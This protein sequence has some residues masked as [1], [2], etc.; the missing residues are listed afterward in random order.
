MGMRILQ[1]PRKLIISFWLLCLLLVGWSLSVNLTVQSDLSQFMPAGASADEAMMLNRLQEGPAARLVLIAIEQGELEQRAASSK[2]LAKLLRESG[3]FT[4][5]KNGEF[6]LDGTERQRLAAHRYLLSPE[7][8][9][10]RFSEQGLRAALM[11][12]LDDLRMPLLLD[13]SALPSDPTAETLAILRNWGSNPQPERIKGVWFSLDTKQALLLAEVAAAGLALDQQQAA[14]DFIKQAFNQVKADSGVH[15]LLSGSPMFATGSREIIR[16]EMTTL[17]TYSTVALILILSLAYRSP[18]LLL[19]AGVPLGA[20]VVAGM[21]AVNWVFDGVHGITLAFGITLLGV[22]IDYPIHLFS[23]LTPEQKPR[24]TLQTIWPTMR[25]GVVTSVL[26]YLA[27]LTSGFPG[28]SQLGLF[29]CAGLAAA[30]LTTKWVVPLFLEIGPLPTFFLWNVK[31]QPRLSLQRAGVVVLVLLGSAV[32]LFLLLRNAPIWQSN[33]R[34]LS[35]IPQSLI[36]QDGELRKAFR[37]PDLNHMLVARAASP[38]EALQLSEQLEVRLVPAVDA[39]LISGFDL[40]SRYLPSIQRQLQRQ[41]L[42]PERQALEAR[43]AAAQQGL[44]FKQGLFAPF[45]EAMEQARE[46]APLSL[47]DVNDGVLGMRL[48]TLLFTEDGGWVLMVPLYG[49]NDEKAFGQWMDQLGLA[50]VRY[51]NLRQEMEGLIDRFRDVALERLGL[52]ALVILFTLSIGLRSLRRG[53]HILTPVCL[54][55]AIDLALLLLMGQLLSLFHL[56]ALLLVMGIGIDYSLFFNRQE[57]DEEGRQRTLHALL[58]CAIS[59]VMVF[60]ILASS[61]IPVLKAIGQTVSI[62]VFFS[63]LAAAFFSPTQ[64]RTSA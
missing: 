61:E 13:K 29:T 35:P 57:V 15:L 21:G 3:L 32:L 38:E 2:A 33:L 63:F 44:P 28:L 55:V 49:V 18:R 39:G 56:I 16:G 31:L 37:T 34:A 62:G 51:I 50:E 1:S 41:S 4:Q 12:R 23:H 5:V 40:A 11:Q 54:A 8:S 52:G 22:A 60:G 9:V 6:G 58:V 25:L 30:I 43:L 26:G 20:A 59:T 48:R 7:V 42:L 64:C 19:L 45:V 10:H 46:M 14:L 53:F 27:L 17:S 47:D 36:T 24:T